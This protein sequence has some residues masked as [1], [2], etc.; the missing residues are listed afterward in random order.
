MRFR[1]GLLAVLASMICATVA[2]AAEN[3]L[4]PQEKKDGWV[5]LF[6]GK[7]FANWRNP[8][9][10]TPPGDAW[11]IED[12]CLHTVKN[13]HIA[14][15]LVS[16]KSYRDFELRFDWRI[17]EGG[18]SGVKYRIQ[19]MVFMDSSKEQKGPGGWEGLVAREV[20]NPRSV[21]SELAPTSTGSYFAMGFEFQLIDDLR[22]PDAK[23]GTTHG[24]GSLYSMIAPTAKA[25]HPAGEWN[26]SL[27]V[28][29]GDHFE[30]WINGVRVL[31]GS[32]DSP[33]VKAGAMERWGKYPEIAKLFT[34]PKPEGPICLQHHGD[35]VWFRNIKIHVLK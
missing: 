14:E 15:D 24:T 29:K 34:E 19:R 26:H 28:V 18:N 21:R 1:K 2:V 23:R 11:V 20:A 16:E 31:S 25:A 12:G 4:T 7:T 33:E 8:L 13:P 3:T 17:S 27:L 6:D 10:E 32:L 9:K 5:L 30:H 22:H 35:L